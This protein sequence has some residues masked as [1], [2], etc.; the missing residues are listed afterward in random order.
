MEQ[1]ELILV[2]LVATLDSLIAYSRSAD[3]EKQARK[4]RDYLIKVMDPDK[5]KP[6][7]SGHDVLN[8]ENP[9]GPG[10]GNP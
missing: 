8:N 10:G 6:T 5:V 2:E 1:A 4:R 7:C 9:A 3:V